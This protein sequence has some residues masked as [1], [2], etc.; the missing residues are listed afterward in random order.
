MLSSASSKPTT[1]DTDFTDD[2]M[3][4]FEE[5]MREQMAAGMTRDQIQEAVVNNDRTVT[6]AF[7]RKLPKEEVQKRAG[8]CTIL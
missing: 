2:I 3:E 1:G 6:N 7:E 5:A 4:K 8:W